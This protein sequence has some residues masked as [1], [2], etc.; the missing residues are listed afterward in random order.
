MRRITTTLALA[1]LVACGGTAAD[2]PVG[3]NTIQLGASRLR[4]TMTASATISQRGSPDTLRAV[5]ENGGPTDVT[6][7]F[8]SSCQILPYLRDAHGTVVL[9][10]HGGW[11]CL[12]VLTQLRIA[13]HDSVVQTFVWTGGDRFAPSTP[14][15]LF[16]AGTYYATAEVPVGRDTL[17]TDP[18][19]ITLVP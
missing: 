9:P 11:G 8:G 2:L 16:P 14:T 15:V 12:A 6:L 13:A 10:D 17:R 1:T 18:L 7:D 19:A 4:L 3:P 5:L